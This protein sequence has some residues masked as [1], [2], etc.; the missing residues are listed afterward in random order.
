M[1]QQ[2][3]DAVLQWL[4]DIM[5]ASDNHLYGTTYD[6]HKHKPHFCNKNAQANHTQQFTTAYNLKL[7]FFLT[8]INYKSTTDTMLMYLLSISTRVYN[9]N[10]YH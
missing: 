4:R 2:N 10:I 1:I 6:E 3:P 8:I 9:T 7:L 5:N